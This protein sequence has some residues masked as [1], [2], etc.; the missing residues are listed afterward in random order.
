MV[1]FAA[2]T[3][4]SLI[5]WLTLALSREDFYAVKKTLAPQKQKGLLCL[6]TQLTLLAFSPPCLFL[7]TSWC[8][9]KAEL[10]QDSS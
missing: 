5:I 3:G 8:C 1:G 7:F 6:P 9:S 10:P 2:K 4:S